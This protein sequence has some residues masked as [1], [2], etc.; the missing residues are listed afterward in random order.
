MFRTCWMLV[1]LCTASIVAAQATP[2]HEKMKA[3]AEAAYQQA[4]FAKCKELTSLVLAQNPKDHAAL[5]FRASSRVELGASKRDIQELREGIQDARE[6]LKLGGSTEINYYLPYLY[7]MVALA[8]LARPKN[9]Q[10][11]TASQHPLPTCRSVYFPQRHGLIH[12]RFSRGDQERSQP[13]RLTCRTGGCLRHGRPTR[14][15]DRRIHR[16]SRNLSQ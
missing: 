6:S 5:Y 10:T 4:D 3:D 11:R 8:N 1:F 15:S 2:E 16:C 14:Q 7:G 13:P 9:T 12:R